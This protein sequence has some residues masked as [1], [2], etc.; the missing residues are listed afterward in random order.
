MREELRVVSWLARVCAL[1]VLLV[2]A[3][4]VS[5][6]IAEGAALAAVSGTVYDSVSREQLRGA[7]VQFVDAAT[8]ARIYS[9]QADSMGRYHIDSLPAGKY[10]AGFFHPSVDVLGIQ[11]PL[12]A[13]TVAPGATNVVDMGIPGAAKV[14][15]TLCGAKAAKDSTAALAGIVRDAGSGEPVSGATVIVKWLEMLLRNKQ[16]ISQERTVPVKTDADGGYRMCGL[17]SHDTL[18]A[19][20]AMNGLQ[21]GGVMLDLASGQIA[22]RDFALG[23]S[24][25]VHLVVLDST[26]EATREE[27]AVLRGTASLTG[28]ALGLQH[29][30]LEGARIVVRGTGLGAVTGS[31]GRF[32]IT[33]LPAGTFSVEAR[34]IGLEPQLIPL[35]FAPGGRKAIQ[36]I[37]DS[38]LPELSRVV[39]IGNIPKPRLDLVEFER[40]RKT[41]VGHF[42]VA[43]DLALRQ[44]ASLSDLF[45]STIGLRVMPTQTGHSIFMRDGCP[46]SVYLDGIKMLEAWET[47]D[48]IPPNQVAGIEIYKGTLEEPARYNG[49]GCGVIL[50]WRKR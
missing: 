45:A 46:A 12:R 49:N 30:P 9:A 24:A 7:Q 13:V 23:D 29:Q 48:D 40:R 14:L 32:M 47:V 16:L 34:S 39:V 20:V 1:L 25:S 36:I 38:K 37:L 44:A 22:R 41:G 26:S 5:A 10:I 43:T 35:D 8:K 17:P 21:S 28:I 50:I 33:D 18:Y 19:Q 2:V 11:S 31:D 15:T 27:T 4:P 3:L 6:Q 42:Y